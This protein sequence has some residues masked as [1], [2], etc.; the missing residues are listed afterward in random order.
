MNHR[1][2]APA[3][4][5]APFCHGPP[6]N[7]AQER[8]ARRHEIPAVPSARSGKPALMAQCGETVH[9]RRPKAGSPVRLVARRDKPRE[10]DRSASPTPGRS[11]G[12]TGVRE[13]GLRIRRFTGLPPRQ[14]AGQTGRRPYLRRRGQLAHP[15]CGAE[16]AEA[17]PWRERS[18]VCP[19]LSPAFHLAFSPQRV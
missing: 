15:S 2:S 10:G 11:R 9:A 12:K 3:A 17:L 8:P 14:V 5:R 16:E 1:T 4:T 7:A 19:F 6:E 18:L 13:H